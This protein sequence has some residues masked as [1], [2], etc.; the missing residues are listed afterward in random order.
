MVYRTCITNV[1]YIE[2]KYGKSHEV[3]DTILLWTKIKET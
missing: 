1:S 2:S 3:N